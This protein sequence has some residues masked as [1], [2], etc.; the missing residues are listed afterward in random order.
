VVVA[1]AAAVPARG[2]QCRAT[3][4]SVSHYR[5]LGGDLDEWKVRGEGGGEVHRAAVNGGCGGA[6][7][8]VAAWCTHE[9][10]ER[11]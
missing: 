4:D 6:G 7:G 10:S 8:T 2:A 11:P 5:F 1:A 3:G 9:G